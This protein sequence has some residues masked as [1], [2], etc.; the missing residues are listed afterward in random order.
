LIEKVQIKKSAYEKLL[1]LLQKHTPNIICG[2][3]V[4]ERDDKNK[5]ILVTDAREIKTRRDTRI[6]FQPVF[7]D[8]RQVADEIHKEGKSIVGE[9]HTHPEGNSNPTG[10]T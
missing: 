5:I 7:S 1:N 4:G 3:L 2:F 9:F 10:E 8:F 6:H